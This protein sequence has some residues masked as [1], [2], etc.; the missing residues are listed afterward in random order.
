MHSMGL[1]GGA[2]AGQGWGELSVSQQIQLCFRL[3]ENTWRAV[4][5]F[6]S[7]HFHLEGCFVLVSWS[8]G[9]C[10]V[11]QATWSPVE[12]ALSRSQVLSSHPFP[13]SL[14]LVAMANTGKR[15]SGSVILWACVLPAQAVTTMIPTFY[16][17]RVRGCICLRGVR[18]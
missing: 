13:S 9:W 17:V 14:C 11:C 8:A 10:P 2:P 18:G 6:M 16:Q 7:S 12:V 3:G 4:R 15:T 5:I 1:E